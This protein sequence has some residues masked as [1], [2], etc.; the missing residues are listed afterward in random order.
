MINCFPQT[1][2]QID[3]FSIRMAGSEKRARYG[4]QPVVVAND[5]AILLD[6][7]QHQYLCRKEIAVI[8]F[9]LF[10]YGFGP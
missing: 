2:S 8:F 4:H 5:A 7:R 1:L 6:H 9:D 3:L 10:T